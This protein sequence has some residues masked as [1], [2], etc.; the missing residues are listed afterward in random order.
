M[1]S[2]GLTPTELG[3]LGAW[4][5][6]YAGAAG[7]LSAE[8]IAGGRSNLTYR[9]NDSAGATWALRRPP[10]GGV[11]HGAHDVAREHRILTGLGGDTAVPAPRV[12]GPLGDAALLGAP[13]IVMEFAAG[14][15]VRTAADAADIS[16]AVR[17]RLGTAAVET[18]A[19][20]HAVDVDAVG[21]GDLGPRSGYLRR[22]LRRWRR[23]LDATGPVDA[24][25]DEGHRRLEAAAPADGVTTLVHGDY[26]LDNLVAAPSGEVTAILDWE[27]ATLGAPLADLALLLV[28]WPQRSGE[29]S[30]VPDPPTV[31]TGFPPRDHIVRRYAHAS[32]WEP[33]ALDAELPYWTAFASWK[34]ACIIHGV[35]TRYG[36][37]FGGGQASDDIEWL[38]AAGE[39][40]ADRALVGVPR[41]TAT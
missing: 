18:L 21:L 19:A 2:A 6:A 41:A 33:G 28:Y 16:T 40:F 5:Q 13:F 3:R 14:R 29:P 20:L 34:L 9:I 38:S 27:L 24:T 17:W 11:L 30:I 26:R 31:L 1:T 7:S 8:L 23:Q 39:A 35:V 32:G 25:L 36:A 12:V 4:F 15:I 22:Q 10:Q 37:G